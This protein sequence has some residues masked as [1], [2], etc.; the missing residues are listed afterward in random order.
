MASSEKRRKKSTVARAFRFV[1][2]SASR[3]W[4][5]RGR[6]A[7]AR[8]NAASNN[9]EIALKLG[10]APSIDGTFD[11]ILANINRNILLADMEHYVNALVQGGSLLLSGFYQADEEA[12]IARANELGL[13]LKNKKSR[14]NWSALQLVK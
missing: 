4:R 9:V 1:W 3:S 14:D 8:E 5:R 6:R 2:F 13:T 11:V 7:N 12:L 10:G